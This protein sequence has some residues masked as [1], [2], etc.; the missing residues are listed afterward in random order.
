M[1]NVHLNQQQLAKRWDISE[2]SLER[3]RSIGI[4]PQFLKINTR[5]LYRLEDI[6]NYERLSLRTSTSER[7]TAGGQV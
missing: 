4:G 2:G 6:E 5:I 3:W 1:S 7:L